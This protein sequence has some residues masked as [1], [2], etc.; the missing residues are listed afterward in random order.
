VGPA[1]ADVVELPGV[2]E[3][4]FAGFVDHVVADP[5]VGVVLAVF[6]RGGFRGGG[7]GGGGGLPVGQG[8]VGAVVVVFAG[9]L[10]DQGLR[11]GDGGA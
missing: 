10:V 3:G 9:E 8:L 2:A 4:D 6:G 11:F 5:V 7:V 1:D